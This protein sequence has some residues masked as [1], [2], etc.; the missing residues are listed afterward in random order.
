MSVDLLERSS[1]A[2]NLA[3]Q[4]AQTMAQAVTMPLRP[5]D[6]LLLSGA[7]PFRFGPDG[8]RQGWSVGDGPVV[9]LVHGYSGR[10]AQMAPLAFRLSVHGFR[11]VFFDAGGH[12]QS[13]AERIGFNTFIDDCR[14][15]RD[16]LGADAFAMIG[17]SAGGLAM[18]RARALNGIRALH[19]V[20]IAAPYYPYVPLETMLKHGAPAETIEYVKVLLSDQ[21]Q[22]TWASLVGGTAYQCE[23]GA[24][25]LA[26]YDKGDEVVR[27]TDLE[28]LQALWPEMARLC[29]EGYG[30]NR[31]L[32]APET[33]EAILKSINE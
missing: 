28:K 1:V 18:M 29:T 3:G 24:K 19:Y 4:L 26:I 5:Q 6:E 25:L 23:P 33:I 30:H 10:G 14:H 7:T 9:V 13:R 8:S 22:T 12:G 27:H 11:A 20:L 15:I 2:L 17:H 32:S 31:I 16:Y 21:F